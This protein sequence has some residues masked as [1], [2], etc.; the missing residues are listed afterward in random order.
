LSGRIELPP[1]LVDA[2]VER[3]CSQVLERLRS[4][5]G[6]PPAPS[7]YCTVT[8]AAEYLRCRPQRV[9]DL[10]SARRL[11]T[12]KEG[13]RTLLRRDELVAIVEAGEGRREGWRS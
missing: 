13:S 11:T 8:E 12:C 10:L 2:L 4:E 3:V 9:R 7:P 5:Q 6:P 1:E